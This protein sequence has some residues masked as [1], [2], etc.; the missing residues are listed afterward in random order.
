MESGEG[1]CGKSQGPHCRLNGARRFFIYQTHEINVEYL[2]LH[3]F[4]AKASKKKGRTD[5]C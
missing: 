2:Y 3:G 5:L 1:L 4:Y